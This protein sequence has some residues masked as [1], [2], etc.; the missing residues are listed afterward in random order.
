MNEK[1]TVGSVVKGHSREG[2][3]Q[4]RGLLYTEEGP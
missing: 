1:F 4:F 2:L 3:V